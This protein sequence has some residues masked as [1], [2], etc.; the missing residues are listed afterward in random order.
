MTGTGPRSIRSYIS[1]DAAAR[2]RQAEMLR[3]TLAPLWREVVGEEIAHHS[4][5]VRLEGKALL[6][7]ADAPL[8]ATQIRHRYT[9]YVQHLQR[10]PELRQ[11]SELRVKIVPINPVFKPT[12]PDITRPQLSS[13]ASDVIEGVAQGI[14]DED[15]REALLRL[16]RRS[17]N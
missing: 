13:N 3:E 7:H 1:G 10:F 12:P 2:A 17:G 4:Y 5:P 15:L 14:E 16:S 6:I 9:D 8:W 11:V